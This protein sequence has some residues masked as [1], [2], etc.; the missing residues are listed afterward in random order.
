MPVC[1]RERDSS[2][3]SDD[4]SYN[5]HLGGVNGRPG[6]F[7]VIGGHQPHTKGMHIWS[8]PFFKETGRGKKKRTAVLLVDTQGTYDHDTPTQ[9][10]ASLFGLSTTVS[11]RIT[12]EE[13]LSPHV[14]L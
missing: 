2:V 13:G 5:G 9:L 3:R 11:R 1:R 6:G 4:P 7:G 8:K 12:W 14:L 10:Q